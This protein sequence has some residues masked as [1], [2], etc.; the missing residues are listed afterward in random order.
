ML[1]H[2]RPANLVAERE[3]RSAGSELRIFFERQLEALGYLTQYETIYVGHLPLYDL[4]L[5]TRDKKGRAL[6]FFNRAC[7]IKASG[8]RALFDLSAS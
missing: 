3:R 8:Q 5:A 1:E 2:E 6:D 7:G 4:F